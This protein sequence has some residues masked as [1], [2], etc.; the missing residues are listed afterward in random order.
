MN[1]LVIDPVWIID[2]WHKVEFGSLHLICPIC[3]CYGHVAKD[4]N[5]LLKVIHKPLEMDSKLPLEVV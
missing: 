2:H 3:G 4:Y 1:L 5:S